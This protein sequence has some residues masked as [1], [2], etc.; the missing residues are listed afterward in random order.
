M[1]ISWHSIRRIW[2]ATALLLLPVTSLPLISHLVGGTLVAPPSSFL[3]G[4]LGAG[5]LVQAFWKKRP[6]PSPTLPLLVFVGLALLSTLLAFFRPVLPFKGHSYWKEAVQAV[7]TLGLGIAVWAAAALAPRKRDDF[8][9]WLRWINTAGVLLVLWGILQA[10]VIFLLHGQYPHWMIRVQSWVSLRDLTR[11]TFRKRVTSFAYEPSWLA[12]MLNTL[13]F[14]YWM[15]AALTGFTACKRRL[16]WLTLERGLLAGGFFVLLASFSRIGLLGFF[17]V[18][19]F[20]V[21]ILAGYLIRWG[22]RHFRHQWLRWMLPL[23]VLLV[24]F[25]VGTAL[26]WLLARHDPRMAQIFN[27][28]RFD[29]IYELGHNLKFGER[30]IYWAL[31]LQVFAAYPLLGVGLGGV[32]FYVPAYLP[33]YGWRL[34]EIIN[35]LVLRDFVFNAKNLWVRLLAE[36]GVLGFAAFT[37]FLLILV[38]EAWILQRRQ[39]NLWRTLGWMGLLAVI[40]LLGEGFSLDTFAFPYFWIASGLMT[41]VLFETQEVNRY[42]EI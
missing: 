18:T 7:S 13:F 3:L 14:P 39:D 23:L 29:N 1:K 4:L 16:G 5:L 2:I 19:G 6:L 8:Y 40:A 28:S 38:L 30:I 35:A 15:A 41:A 21:L 12:H 26:V 33:S 22:Q 9:S 25:A 24:F 27:L 37:V 11:V 20:L 31:G 34:P 32:G 10:G 17:A 36:T 42:E